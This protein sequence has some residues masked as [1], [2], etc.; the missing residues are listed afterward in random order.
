MDRCQHKSVIVV[1]PGAQCLAPGSILE[2]WENPSWYPCATVHNV[3]EEEI[4]TGKR[5]TEAEGE[6]YRFFSVQRARIRLKIAII[7]CR[8]GKRQS[9]GGVPR[10]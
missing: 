1:G 9:K 4:D 5:D 6:R 2:R 7:E 8:G 10:I 3:R